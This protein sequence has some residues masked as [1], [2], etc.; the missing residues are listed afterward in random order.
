MSSSEIII[1]TSTLNFKTILKIKVLV[2]LSKGCISTERVCYQ[3]C[4]PI[5]LTDPMWPGRS[6]V[7]KWPWDGIVTPWECFF[8]CVFPV[9]PWKVLAHGTSIMEAIRETTLSGSLLTRGLDKHVRGKS[10]RC[11][12]I[13]SVF[14][15][16]PSF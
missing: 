1:S 10:S 3:R 14:G 4:Y 8:L 13:N 11:L 15:G 9:L 12:H 5:K 7:E 6:T 16:S 2:R